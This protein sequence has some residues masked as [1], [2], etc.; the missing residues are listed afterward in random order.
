M[1][2]SLPSS[3]VR[4]GAAGLLGL[5]ACTLPMPALAADLPPVDAA[6]VLLTDVSRSIDDVEFKLEKE[7]YAA[8]F[9]DPRVLAAIAAGPNARIAI[10]YM[11]FAGEGQT[12]T[13]LDWTVVD[14]ASTAAAFTGSLTDAPRSFYGR[15]AIGSAIVQATA[16]LS[17]AAPN[18]AR[19]I[20]DV[21]GDGTSN[22]G[23]AV[24]FA[25]DQALAAGITINGLAIINDHPVSYTFAHVQPPGGLT[26]WYRDNVS[27]G[28]GSF[29]LEVHDF[30]TFGEAMARKL[31]SEIAELPAVKG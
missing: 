9:S 15:T 23:T 28:P 17:E 7:G 26:Q 25:R 30:H 3:S 12:K 8:A 18:A 1:A 31:I 5:A 29:V 11:E 20:I 4:C 6:L 19:A 13:V 21:A 22:S 2:F 27:G 14:G 24:T 16:L 10:A